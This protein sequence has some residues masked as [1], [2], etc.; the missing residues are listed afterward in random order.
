MNIQKFLAPNARAAM[1][2]AR[3]AFGEKTMILSNRD[4]IGGVEIT[5]TAEESAPLSLPLSTKHKSIP[6][7]PAPAL[8]EKTSVA[9]DTEELAMST[10]SF[11]D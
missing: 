9:N 10:L 4:V 6:N 11:Q 5:A 7:T 8:Y 3:L 2:L 1:N